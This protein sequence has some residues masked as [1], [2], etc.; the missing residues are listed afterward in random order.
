MFK[1]FVSADQI[2]AF[3][4]QIAYLFEIRHSHLATAGYPAVEMPPKTELTAHQR[5]RIVSQLVLRGHSAST[6][7]MGRANF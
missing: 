7:E 3:F 6:I 1:F 2:L 4:A 5:K